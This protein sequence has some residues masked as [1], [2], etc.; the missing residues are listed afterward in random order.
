MRPVL[1]VTIDGVL[2]HIGFSQVLRVVEALATRGVPYSLVSMERAR[3][4]GDTARV[5]AVRARLRAAGIAWESAPYHEGGAATVA[6][7]LGRLTAL[8]ARVAVVARAGLVHARGYHGALVARALRATLR[9]P[10]LFDA[11]GFW[12][13]ERL[14]EGR[15][16]TTPRRL[17]VARRVEHRLYRDARGIVTLTELH[18]ADVTR[19][20]LPR[21]ARPPLVIPTCADYDQFRI[22]PTPSVEVVPMDVR[23]ALRGRRVLAIVGSLNRAYL[24]RDAGRLMR[25]V[26]ARDPDARLLVLS[27]QSDAW[28]TCLAGCGVPAEATVL[29]RADHEAMP[30]WLSLVD[31]GLLVLTPDT[32]AKRAMMPTKLAEFFAAGVGP[33]AHGCNPEVRDWVARAGS[34]IVLEGLG[35]DALDAAAA[36]ICQTPALG[37]REHARAI[38]A[39]HFSLA[40]GVARYAQL[41]EALATNESAG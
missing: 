1:Y 9:V 35:D 7:N 31:F 17:R 34:G 14:E 5:E 26:L 19:D 40:S 18:A 32:V 11:R 2:D 30:A 22:A 33:V 3:D 36:K 23:Q 29:A 27:G 16:F 6:E 13:D 8:A 21:G 39:P 24:G 25:A 12:I 38:T 10:Y 41:L 20:H 37:V 4:L 28:R 15:W